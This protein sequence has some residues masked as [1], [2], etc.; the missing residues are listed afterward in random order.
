MQPAFNLSSYVHIHYLILSM[1]CTK[2]LAYVM[3]LARSMKSPPFDLSKQ[4]NQTVAFKQYELLNIME[5]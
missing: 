5:L 1:V 4:L 2:Y 3:C